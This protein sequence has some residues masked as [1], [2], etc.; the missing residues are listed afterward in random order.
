MR[1]RARNY[2]EHPTFLGAAQ[3][4]KDEPV[5]W[6]DADEFDPP[7]P[8]VGD[9]PQIYDLDV[10]PYEIRVSAAR[11]IRRAGFEIGAHVKARRH[12]GLGTPRPRAPA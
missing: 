2:F 8:G 7:D 4:K 5:F 11:W 6:M 3:W 10:A 12:R 9:P 1:S